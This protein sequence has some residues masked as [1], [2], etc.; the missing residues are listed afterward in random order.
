MSRQI[1]QDLKTSQTRTGRIE[2]AV[3]PCVFSQGFEE[4]IN[5]LVELRNRFAD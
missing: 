1:P 3:E 2:Q 5:S 4:I